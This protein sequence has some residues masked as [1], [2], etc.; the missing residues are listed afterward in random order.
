MS[1][2]P[3]NL[4]SLQLEYTVLKSKRDVLWDLQEKL[5]TYDLPF[6]ITIIASSLCSLFF[7]HIYVFEMIGL[8][9]A[10]AYLMSVFIYIKIGKMKEVYFT[11]MDE[12]QD[13]QDVPL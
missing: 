4:S 12:L 13:K 10:G 3:K 2:Q 6:L 11:L 7:P 8:V 5:D 9:L 1:S